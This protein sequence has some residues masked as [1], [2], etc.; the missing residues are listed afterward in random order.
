MVTVAPPVTETE[1]PASGPGA[2]P[3]S[4]PTPPASG[5]GVPASTE[6]QHE[7]RCATPSRNTQPR[8]CA[9]IASSLASPRSSV[10]SGETEVVGRSTVL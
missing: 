3:P 6:S 9:G 1:V 7:L 5:S 8:T 10:W 4:A 2:D